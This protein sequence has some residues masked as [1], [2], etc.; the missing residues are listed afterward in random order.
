[1]N[2]TGVHLG[3]G[4]GYEEAL[5]YAKNLKCTSVQIFTHS[6]RMFK[7][8]ELDPNRQQ[9]LIEGWEKLGIYPVVS[10]AS[11][12]INIGSTDNKKFYGALGIL[13][14]ELEYA[15]AF[16]CHYL[17]YHVGKYTG[18]TPEEGKAQIVK[19]INKLEKTLKKTGVML[20]LENSA[21]QGTE[22]GRNFTELK[23]ILDAV[24]SSVKPHLGVC[25]DT[26]HLFASGYDITKPE[27]VISEFDELVG[28]EHLKVIH[29]NDSKFELG[30]KKDR[31]AH[32]GKGFIGRE[33]LK[34]FL[35]HKSIKELPMILETPIDEEGEQADDLRVLREIMSKA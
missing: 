31:H 30:G 20:L 15:A 8:K 16:G 17:V 27:S 33:G 3:L 2:P 7:F 5:D 1:M 4:M 19:G 6:P 12:L 28:L 13:E 29:V 35:T 25:L 32:L 9:V 18:G 24:E 26:C 22:L 34:A 23:E 10:H 21:G 14:K 11:Y